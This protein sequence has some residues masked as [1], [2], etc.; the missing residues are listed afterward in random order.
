MVAG[1]SCDVFHAS[2]LLPG[3]PAKREA[4]TATLHDLTTW[5]LLPEYVHMRGNIAGR[6][7]GS[8]TSHLQEAVAFDRLSV[9]ILA[10][11]L[12][13]ALDPER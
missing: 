12:S 10:R 2:N 4:I 9:S 5:V 7:S 8:L 1:P 6:E 13:R 11:T 3:L